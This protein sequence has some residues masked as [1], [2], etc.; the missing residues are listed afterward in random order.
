MA[1]EVIA[2]NPYDTKADIWSLGITIM[3]MCLGDPPNKEIDFKHIPKMKPPSLP[4][5]D[6]RFSILIKEFVTLCLNE[7]PS[8][9][10]TAEDLTKTKLMKS[11]AKAPLTPLKDLIARYGDWEKKGGI[12]ASL[13]P[14]A[15]GAVLDGEGRRLTVMS[16]GGW[17]FE[18]GEGE[19][20]ESIEEENERDCKPFSP[21][22]SL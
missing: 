18:G 12:R 9:R 16:M 3:E 19:A 17:D 13:A 5:N 22:E 8:E 7:V 4:A 15:P 20:F 21:F 6:A 1:P 10:P 11:V 14:G 2:G